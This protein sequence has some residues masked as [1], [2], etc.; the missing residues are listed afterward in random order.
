MGQFGNFDLHVKIMEL[1]IRLPAQAPDLFVCSVWFGSW[2][3]SS[4]GKSWKGGCQRLIPIRWPDQSA[5]RDLAL[6]SH[7]EVL[8]L[9]KK[10]VFRNKSYQSPPLPEPPLSLTPFFH[11][12]FIYQ[13]SPLCR[14]CVEP[15][16]YKSNEIWF[17]LSRSSQLGK[18]EEPI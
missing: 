11:C 8:F 6:L 13:A 9:L 17:L 2:F 14:L 12:T 5:K 15:W 1:L 16:K 10:A 7:S 3:G 18:E 4:D